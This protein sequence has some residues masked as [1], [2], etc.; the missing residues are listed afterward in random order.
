MFKLKNLSLLILFIIIT[1]TS[2]AQSENNF[3]NVPYKA[4]GL[5]LELSEFDKVEDYW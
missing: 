5:N 4:P 2:N 3:S 1:V